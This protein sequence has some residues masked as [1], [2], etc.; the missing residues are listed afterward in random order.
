MIT[1]RIGVGGS[2]HFLLCCVTENKGSEWYFMKDRNVTV[3]KYHKA[4]FC[5]IVTRLGFH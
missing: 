4:F 5:T 3:I 2:H 1:S